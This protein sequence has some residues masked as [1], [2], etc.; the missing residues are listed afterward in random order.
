M[1][2]QVFIVKGPENVAMLRKHPRTIT[3]PGVTTFVL[4]T[5]FGMSR[6]AVD[7]YTSDESGIHVKARP[8]TS[9]K[10]H[11]RIDHLTHAN[12]HKHLLGEG[13][14]R[15]YQDFADS[16]LRRLP[17]LD[18]GTQW[19]Y[20]GD[21]LDYWLPPMTSA[22]NEALAGPILECVNPTF[23]D[24]LLEYY[25][26]LHS[27]LK[28]VPR[29]IIPKAYKLQKS[30]LRDVATWHA[31]AR[32]R[33]QESDIDKTTGRDPWWGSAFMRERQKILG[34]VDGWDAH[35]IAASDFGIFW[36][37][38]VNIHPMA[39]WTIIE[40]FKDKRLLCRVR[41]ELTNIRFRGIADEEDI[42]KL[43]TSPLLQSIYNELLRLRVEVQTIFS[44]GD[45]E[46]HLSNC[47]I[48]KGSLVVVPAGDA[49]KDPSVW[50]TRSGQYPLNHFWAD[51]F[52]V[53]QGDPQSGPQKA[54]G[55]DSD[56]A[57][58][59]RHS[60]GEAKP[61]LAL[62][63]LA[64]TFMPFGIGERTCPGRGFARREIIMFCALVTYRYDMEFL[65]DDQ[66]FDTTQAY[67]G[68][69][70]QRPKGKIPFRIRLTQPD[71]KIHSTLP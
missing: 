32:A 58:S 20:H 61:K 24:D 40:V 12:F 30:L 25:P 31:I 53:Y 62:S 9:V 37:S 41:E 43:M 38:S 6:T 26:Y 19:T 54:L 1:G 10:T 45:E 34:R 51:R 4:R 46:I 60:H 50:N 65:C 21:L 15:I 2:H 5:L 27:L 17:S 16:L 7:M 64:D 3:T 22:M 44:S 29:W 14:G 39:L 28:G 47:R 71:I 59:C 56:T 23:A 67:Y 70:T 57:R 66:N 8:H 42:A 55:S 36:G 68:I 52:L 33:F 35:S 18:I 49:H 11:N 69:G 13:L 48:P 63:G